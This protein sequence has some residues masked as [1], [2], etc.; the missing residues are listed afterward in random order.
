MTTI[1]STAD[2]QVGNWLEACGLHGRPARRGEIIEVLG[3]PGHQRYR[4]RWDD[5]HESVVFPADGVDIV[6]PPKQHPAHR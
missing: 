3:Q 5:Q 2:A 6:H 4:V 1:H